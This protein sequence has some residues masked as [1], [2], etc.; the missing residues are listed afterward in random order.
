MRALILN[1]VFAIIVGIAVGT[2]ADYALVTAR[3]KIQRAEA[4]RLAKEAENDLKRVV[5]AAE[6]DPGLARELQARI[7]EHE[8]RHARLH[9]E[10]THIRAK[11]APTAR[12]IAGAGF[13][14]TLGVLL[15]LDR[16]RRKC[17]SPTVSSPGLPP[18]QA[19]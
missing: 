12:A 16:L 4:G 18:E 8:A 17:R 6:I 2:I 11:T 19:A 14:V 13:V 3:T 5:M 15:V 7:K 9:S 10:I 1:I